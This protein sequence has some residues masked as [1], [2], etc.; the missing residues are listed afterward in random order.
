MKLRIR[1]NSLRL[2]LTRTEV[3]D[4]CRTG[5]VENFILLGPKAN[6]R[7]T[8]RVITDVESQELKV[9][10]HEGAIT[11]V[12]PVESAIRW[13]GSEEVG[14]YGEERLGEQDSLRVMV[15][16]DFKC[17]DKRKEEDETDAYP[18]PLV[19]RRATAAAK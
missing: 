7:L 15:E 16:K 18:H 5:V 13:G 9:Q 12:I 14:L 19:T 4:L 6:D 8:Y 10:Y 3:S 17:L 11:V 2:R 1:G